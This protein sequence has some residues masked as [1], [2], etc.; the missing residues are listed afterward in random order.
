V[1]AS[2]PDAATI[3]A[4]SITGGTGSTAFAINPTTG[5][6]TVLDT[7]QLN[8]EVTP[9]FSLTVQVSDGA[10]TASATITINLT[11]VNEAP[12]VDANGAAAGIDSATAYTERAAA[13]PITTASLT[14][15]DQENDSIT[16]AVVTITNLA[17][18]A[19]ESLA[20][21]P[22]GGITSVYVGG[23][24]T[25]TG[26]A[27]PAAFQTV[28]QT[29]TYANTSSNPGTSR[30]I[31]IVA[32]DN[33]AP[34]ATSS[35]ATQIV[36]TITTVNDPPTV[37]AP[38]LTVNEG[39]TANI[40]AAQLSATDPDTLP[41]N[42][43]FTITSLTTNG[44]LQKNGSIL[45]NGS[46]FT[47]ADIGSGLLSYVHNGSE[48]TTDSFTF[49]LTDG[50]TA[51]P[52]QAFPIT[53]VPTNDAPV[54]TLTTGPTAYQ[55]GATPVVIDAG[56]TVTDIDSLNFNGGQ[57]RVTIASGAGA[58]DSLSVRNEGT[59]AGQ[60]S[61]SGLLISFGG[62]QIGAI[63]S[64]TTA[65]TLVITL[66][67]N[68]TPAAVQA[69]ARNITFS[70][71]AASTTPGSRVATFTVND[72]GLDSVP[73]SKTITFNQPP[74]AVN[75]TATVAINST[76]SITV[77]AND[78]DADSDV[79]TV[80]AVTQ[81]A[82]GTVV[83]AAAGANLTY[84]PA[85]DYLGPDSFT[86]TISDGRG[87]SATATVQVTVNKAA[88]YLPLIMK[89]A[90]ADL[91]VS[92]TVT[93]TT[94]TAGQP[95]NITVTVTNIGD[96]PASN[97]WVDF[98]I[99]P[100]SVPQ[101]NDRWN[102]LCR[103]E[104]FPCYG[105][106]WYY[107][108]TLAPGQSVVLNSNEQSTSNPNGF[109]KDASIWPGYFYNGVTKLYTIADSWNRDASGQIRD[110]QG[111]IYERD[112]SNNGSSQDITVDFGFLPARV[113]LNRIDNLSARN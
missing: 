84:T 87:G 61:K 63:G 107:T 81:G 100:T 49:T 78:S 37:V 3:L 113:R 65:T 108:D 9:S 60:I 77:L 21:T 42:L 45:S 55:L 56:A 66:N 28:L 29:L 111:A 93:P 95:T 88:I 103:P 79:L 25:L 74:L 86:Y 22:S 13:T 20:V 31:S 110:P 67:T 97:F 35:P 82:H 12:V 15:S 46:T 92:F 48:T 8:F 64:S 112:E 7:T 106:A 85:I 102:D 99:D 40:T 16:S 43:V 24:L 98:Y 105:L 57:L 109:K 14:V 80:T 2:D 10:L 11:N 19:A 39:G 38:G 50:T 54:L 101:V 1:V 32:T 26:P 90:Y 5:A 6:I 23:T 53:I 17:N 75:D 51:L 68:A 104:G 33:G 76:T 62:V 73:Q 89:P 91:K 52:A 27:T 36:I 34:P 59:A 18:G 71:T 94:P 96:G 72:G 47:Q 30:T 83:I 58:G 41:A 69:L 70:N 4:Y 44:Q